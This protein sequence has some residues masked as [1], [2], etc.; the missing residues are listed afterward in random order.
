MFVPVADIP[1][2]EI[3]EEFRCGKPPAII[4][5]LNQ[6]GYGFKLAFERQ[7][8]TYEYWRRE[9]SVL[10]LEYGH[11]R[12]CIFNLTSQEPTDKAIRMMEETRARIRELEKQR[13]KRY[14]KPPNRK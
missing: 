1:N 9:H 10:Q 2:W 3:Y 6:R 14:V 7:G 11:G 13:L 4:A 12:I 8:Y 5:E